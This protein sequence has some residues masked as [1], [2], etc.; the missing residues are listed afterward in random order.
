M[1]I[2]SWNIQAAKGVDGVVSVDRIAS[3]IKTFCDADVICLQEVLRTQLDD[4]VAT[5][6]E[7]F[8][9]Y[10]VYFGPA[11]NRLYPDGRLW[12]GNLILSRVPVQAA[13]NHKLPQP[14]EPQAKPMPR[15]AIELILTI[16]NRHLRIVTTHLEYFAARQRSHQVQYLHDHYLETCQRF[17]H[18]SPTGGSEQFE[19][20]PETNLSLYAGD[21]NLTVDTPDYQTMT[22]E[23]DYGALQDCWRLL[24]PG[25]EHPPTCGIFDRVQWQE[26]PHCRD[27]FFTSA[28][29]APHV[30]NMATQVETAASDH[31]PISLSLTF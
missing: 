28:S 22:Q 17:Q 23:T 11:I 5:F 16:N 9:G 15:Q 29:L 18:P 6:A 20:L 7:H 1:N 31:Q 30:S 25:V 19:T 14:A 2:L 12:F 8:A 10:D 13:F 21:F 27:Y 4:Q 24:H 26:G 3:D